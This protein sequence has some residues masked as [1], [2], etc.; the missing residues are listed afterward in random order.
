MTRN[1]S[2]EQTMLDAVERN[3]SISVHAV[4]AAVGVSRNNVHRVL[5]GEALHP[6]H[7]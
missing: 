6:Y 1:P 4:A 3:P 2:M 5:Q 7:L